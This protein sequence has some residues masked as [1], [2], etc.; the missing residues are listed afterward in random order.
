MDNYRIN[1]DLIN[2]LFD[3]NDKS[4]V[5]ISEKSLTNRNEKI[6]TKNFK[7]KKYTKKQLLTAIVT[8]V[9][10]SASLGS[11]ATHSIDSFIETQEQ[12]DTLT[13]ALDEYQSKID[14][15]VDA[16]S[17][18]ETLS[19]PNHALGPI[20]NYDSGAIAM[21]IE[22]DFTTE[23]EKDIAIY[24]L[25]NSYGKSGDSACTGI[26]S[27]TIRH[28]NSEEKYIGLEDYVEKKGFKNL[29]DYDKK[30]KDYIINEYNF[31]KSEN[32]VGGKQWK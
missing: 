13:K 23:K 14:S 20:V 16:S 10:L 31:N 8:S 3:E 6:E 32:L 18:R 11:I 17:I 24:T 2:I 21:L 7:K 30:M 25:Y 27:N 12:E 15:I 26:T 19:T 4:R 9:V 1:E 22:K 5:K 28:L 29:E